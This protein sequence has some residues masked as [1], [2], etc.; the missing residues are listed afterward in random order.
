MK[1][2]SPDFQ[3]LVSVFDKSAILIPSGAGLEFGPISGKA[4]M[5]GRHIRMAIL[6]IRETPPVV[7]SPGA[8]TTNIVPSGTAFIEICDQFAEGAELAVILH[9]S[10]VDPKGQLCKQEITLGNYFIGKNLKELNNAPYPKEV[11]V[12]RGAKVGGSA[13][14]RMLYTFSGTQELPFLDDKVQVAVF[15][16]HA[17]SEILLTV[18]ER[19]T[20]L[21]PVIFIKKSISYGC[22]F[23]VDLG[24]DERLPPD[25]ASWVLTRDE[26]KTVM[27]VPM[28]FSNN[29]SNIQSIPTPGKEYTIPLPSTNWHILINGQRW[30]RIEEGAIKYTVKE[31]AWLKLLPAGDA[32]ASLLFSNYNRIALQEVGNDSSWSPLTNGLIV[33]T[34]SKTFLIVQNEVAPDLSMLSALRLSDNPS[35]NTHTDKLPEGQIDRISR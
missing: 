2:L 26:G 23:R 28:A 13:S 22:L 4:D 1:P 32:T 6:L 30:A 24:N 3:R 16:N 21:I 7:L 18:G 12:L 11:D 8:T 5:K 10:L 31:Q 20:G 34:N 25:F 15:E 19:I 9:T 35:T 33:P 17:P 29:W 14:R 27:N